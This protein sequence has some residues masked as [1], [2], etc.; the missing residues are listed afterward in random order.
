[1]S[2]QHD[3]RI[4]LIKHNM[5]STIFNAPFGEVNAAALYDTGA[6]LSVMSVGFYELIGSPPLRR[7]QWR[8][9]GAGGNPLR[10]HGIY[11]L[12][13][14]LENVRNTSIDDHN[15]LQLHL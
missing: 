14:G 8:L 7:F 13:M 2:H 12:K 5:A 1:M 9:V 6:M 4:A 10:V 15:T 3:V 11:T